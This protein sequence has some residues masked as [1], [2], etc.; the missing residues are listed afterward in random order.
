[1]RSIWVYELLFSIYSYSSKYR[2]CTVSQEK[3][4]R[5]VDQYPFMARERL[6]K[7]NRYKHSFFY[8]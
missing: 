3:I 1:M 6:L 2:A 4:M 5:N 7:P 8:T